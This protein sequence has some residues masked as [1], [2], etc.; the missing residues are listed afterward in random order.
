MSSK[1]ACF[2]AV[3]LPS[4][5]TSWLI[6]GTRVLRE[7]PEATKPLIVK[8]GTIDLGL[9][10][11]TPVVFRGRLYRFE[12]VRER[13]KQNKTGAGATLAFLPLVQWPRQR[14]SQNKDRGE[15]AYSLSY[16]HRF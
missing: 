1:F 12:Y 6:A 10:E 11:T 7:Q 4:L 2:S 9:V 14:Q 16:Q 13:Y 3:I 8:R 15:A 5:F